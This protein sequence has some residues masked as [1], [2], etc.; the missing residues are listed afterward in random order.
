MNLIIDVGNTFVKTAV[1]NRQTIIFQKS[2]EALD[3]T[4]EID[5][6]FKKYSTI[7]DT[8]LSSVSAE[9]KNLKEILSK[10]TTVYTVTH[11]SKIPFK[12]LYQTPQTLGVD[13]I[14][15]VSAAVT[16]YPNKNILIIDA[17]TCITYDFL[18]L[19]NQ[20]LGGAISPGI[21]MRFNALHSFTANLPLINL[22]DID[23][24]IGNTTQTSIQ[25]GVLYGVITEIDGIINRYKT[26]YGDLTVILTGGDANFL[27]KRLKNPIFAH[28]NLLLEGLNIILAHNKNK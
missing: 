13:R 22:K 27:S 15:L 6:I 16:T 11:Q 10:K 23:D 28:S 19:E 24:I 3:F 2:F 9:I 8:I 1:F 14:A 20:Y 17:G 21:S 7:E 12:N 5:A 18:N 4:A 26:K 25:S